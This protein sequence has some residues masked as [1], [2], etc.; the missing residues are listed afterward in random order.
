MRGEREEAVQRAVV[1][2]F[3]GQVGQFGGIQQPQFDAQ[4]LVFQGGLILAAPETAA[5][6]A[7]EDRLEE[8][9]AES[10]GSLPLRRADAAHAPASPPDL[11]EKVLQLQVG[12]GQDELALCLASR[13]ADD[14][15]GIALFTLFEPYLEI[16]VLQPVH[17]HLLL[18]RH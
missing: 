13:R 7:L 8:L 12:E 5:D 1:E 15:Y 4:P 16:E 18:G 6:V 10:R 17:R 3:P 2:V 11:Q 14:A 9:A